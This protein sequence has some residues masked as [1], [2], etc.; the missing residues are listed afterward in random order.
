MKPIYATLVLLCSWYFGHAQV[1]TGCIK[2]EGG[3][4]VKNVSVTLRKAVDSA[5]VKL[6]V[7]DSAGRFTFNAPVG[8]YFIDVSH[9]GYS[10]ARSG[11]VVVRDTS[12]AGDI[13]IVLQKTAKILKEVVVTAQKPVIE[14]KVDKIL[15]KCFQGILLTGF[16]V[17]QNYYTIT[18][19][20]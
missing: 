13:I 19:V 10:F 18:Q 8:S 4:G 2:D 16:L 17:L 5:V 1:I 3:Y 9:T 15:L 11:R 20:I 6:G 7:S 12:V 14:V